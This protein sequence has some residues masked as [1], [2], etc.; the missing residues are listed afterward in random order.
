[1]KE[2]SKEEILTAWSNTDFKTGVYIHS[3]FCKE[4]CTYCTFKGTLFEK[5]AFNRYYSE[6]LPNQ[7]KFYEPI[8]SSDRIHNYFWGGG[9]PTLMSAEIMRNIFG[10]IPNFKDCKK[11]IM[12][13][14]MCDWTKEQ[15]D[16]LKE[17]NFN[18][19]IACVQSFDGEVVKQQKRRAPKNNDVI[20]N[21]LDYANTLGLFTMSDIIFFDTGDMN[22]DLDRLSSDMQKLAD[23]DISEIS[24]QTI[25]DEVG[26][27][28][29]QVTNRVNEFLYL[30][31]QYHKGFEREHP[32]SD[33]ADASGRKARKEDKIYKKEIDWEEMSQQDIHLDGLMTNPEML[34]AT[35]YNVLGIG[36]YKNHKYTFSRIED[37]L[38][39]VEVGDTY[40]P[41]WLCTY[42]KKDWP[43]K[44]L[45]ADFYT[46]LE[47][48]IGDPPDG[49][50]FTF[51]SEVVQ[52]DEDDSTKKRVERRLIPSFR[53]PIRDND[54]IIGIEEY[55]SKLRKI[56]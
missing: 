20:Y 54:P 48:T 12:E 15:L 55:V 18:T 31:T 8:L 42:D 53:W 2:L 40:T 34:F 11:K 4:Q 35:N 1:M 6:Y 3:P 24:V 39:Y 52:Y 56:L 19:V 16:V 17:Y 29:V 44:K 27:Y 9:T 37:K 22:R 14:H 51:S 32:E 38:E 25:F 13:F 10:L 21:F 47:N 36:S 30:N 33:F 45:V 43:M 7:I 23:H 49:V 41:K 46:M 50:D 28:D 26:K 5:T